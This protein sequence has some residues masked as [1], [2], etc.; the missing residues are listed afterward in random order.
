MSLCDETC[1][2]CIYHSTITGVGIVCNYIL[3]NYMPLGERRRGCPAGRGCKQRKTGK[4][5]QSIESIIFRGRKKQPESDKERQVAA[6][7]EYLTTHGMTYQQL[8]DACG[9]ISKSTI[10]NWA[11]GVNRAD[12]KKL[13]KAGITKP[14][15]T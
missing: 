7:K 10:K 2:P 5:A 11:R 3:D 14:E 13:A 15:G 1:R 12:W 8:G 4:R 9:G 6:I